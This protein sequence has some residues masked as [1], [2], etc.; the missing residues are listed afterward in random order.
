MKEDGKE[1]VVAAPEPA[2]RTLQSINGI[3]NRYVLPLLPS[4]PPSPFIFPPSLPSFF[5]KSAAARPFSSLTL[6]PSLPPSSPRKLT[7]SGGQAGGNGDNNSS[8]G[9]NNNGNGN[10]NW[11]AQE[12]EK[13]AGGK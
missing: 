5:L 12:T 11:K 6:P 8:N 13:D 2:H 7:Y 10:G 4:L 3:I 9:N 1:E